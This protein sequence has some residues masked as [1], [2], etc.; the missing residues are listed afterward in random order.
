MPA[1]FIAFDVLQADGQELLTEPYER[2][3]D[4]LENLFTEHGLT[5]PWTLC[6]MT[7]DPGRRAGGA[8][9]A[10]ARRPS[11]AVGSIPTRQPHS[12]VPSPSSPRPS[13]SPSPP[14]I[15]L[16]CTCDADAFVF[17]QVARG[18]RPLDPLS[19]FLVPGVWDRGPQ[20]ALD[21]L[22]CGSV[23]LATFLGRSGPGRPPVEPFLPG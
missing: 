3:R 14:G 4:V 7:T 22:H 23:P 11:M 18:D 20:C 17:R 13:I 16:T 15:W 19:P 1:H 6:P 12:V 9:A 21:G 8:E 5:P 10:P 2:R